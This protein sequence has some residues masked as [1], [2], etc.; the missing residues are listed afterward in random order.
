MAFILASTTLEWSYLGD[1]VKEWANRVMRGA[2][3]RKRGHN[4][5]NQY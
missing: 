5:L 3:W 4:E 2:K 1:D